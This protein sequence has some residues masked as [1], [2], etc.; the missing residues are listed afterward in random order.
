MHIHTYREIWGHMGLRMLNTQPF[1]SLK[2]TFSSNAWGIQQIRLQSD[3]SRQTRAG[4]K[5]CSNT[6]K[7]HFAAQMMEDKVV[8]FVL[9]RGV[10]KCNSATIEQVSG[11]GSG[12]FRRLGWEERQKGR[13][14]W[15]VLRLGETISEGPGLGREGVQSCFTS[16]AGG[17][18]QVG[19]LASVQLFAPALCHKPQKQAWLL[20]APPACSPVLPGRRREPRTW[21]LFLLLPPWMEP[22]GCK[23]C[24]SQA[25][26]QP[27]AVTAAASSEGRRRQSVHAAATPAPPLLCRHQSRRSAASGYC[28]VPSMPK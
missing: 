3:K 26:E 19:C 15:E 22:R 12:A 24:P 16:R 1:L 5:I 9:I 28:A 17:W 7:L 21:S 13:N 10:V 2:K 6:S 4:S 25:L 20:R 23:S 27:L 18:R 14:E 11:R 8:Y